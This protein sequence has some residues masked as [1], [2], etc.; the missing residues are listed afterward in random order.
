MAELAGRV[1]MVTGATRGIG[2]AVA[3]ELAAC[4]AHV[5]A[6][7]RDERGVAECVEQIA[8]RT[9]A[10]ATGAVFDVGDFAGVG[11]AIRAAVRPHGRLDVMVA[12]AGVMSSAPLG[13]IV[14]SD[15]RTL[16]DT[17]VAGVIASIQAAGRVMSRQRSGAI[18]VTG[19]IVGRDGAAGQVAYSA[20]KA[21]VVGATR[22]AAK[23]LGQWGVRV[24]AVAPGM[25]DTGLIAQVPPDVRERHVAA[26]PLGR[27][28]TAV[29]V[30]K[31]VRFLAGDDAAFVTGQVVGVDGGLVL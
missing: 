24:N 9:G 26:T 21:A 28:G 31:V 8:H 25:V 29:D 27:L 17:N 5:I 16:L 15:L 30:A 20:S 3:V 1:A 7:G 6:A 22:S 18:V 14:E 4:G 2:F 11:P 10:T 19:S 13:M 12:N 23:E